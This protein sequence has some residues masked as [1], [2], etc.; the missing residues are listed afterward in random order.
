MALQFFSW[1]PAL[2]S[3]R[4]SFATVS[5]SGRCPSN[6]FDPVE[7][8][9]FYEFF[10]T[11]IATSSLNG[12]H[13]Q[14]LIGGMVLL[15]GAQKFHNYSMLAAALLQEELNFSKGLSKSSGIDLDKFLEILMEFLKNIKTPDEKEL[16]RSSLYQKNPSSMASAYWRLIL[17]LMKDFRKSS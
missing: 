4:K 14:A 9:E 13:R 6:D 10:N 17:H 15:Y 11:Q 2:L 7:F 8:K 12:S 1:S 16:F 3:A 5:G